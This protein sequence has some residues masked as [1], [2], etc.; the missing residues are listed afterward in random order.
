MN[1]KEILNKNKGF[2]EFL[3]KIGILIGIFLILPVVLFPFLEMSRYSKNN[4]DP[5][6]HLFLVDIGVVVLVAILA[7]ILISRDKLIKIKEYKY[8]KRPGLIFT[9]C[10]LISITSYL[11]LRYYTAHN[12]QTALQYHWLFFCLILVNVILIF[13]F[14]VLAIFNIKFIIDFIDNFKKELSLCIGLSIIAYI[15]IIK[16]RASWYLLGGFVAKSV[17]FLLK[18]SFKNEVMFSI[19]NHSIIL[20]VRN[21]TASIGTPCSGIE[22]ISMFLLLF[23]LI[24]AYDYK[25]LNKKRMFVVLIPGLI[26]TVLVNILRIYLLYLA[27]VFVSPQFA[28]GM[29]HSNIGWILFLVYFIFFW[30]FAY[31][32]VKG[33]NINK[34]LKEYDKSKK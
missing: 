18:L 30:F 8:Y 14:M 13:F 27:G 19:N 7:F 3:I 12:T 24:F 5:L 1:L 4:P 31:K 16:I 22:S 28:V 23:L 9:I 25:I 20:G 33:G 17:A 32:W 2:K 26:G 10:S 15:F 34:K 21:F 6:G 11:I 29:F